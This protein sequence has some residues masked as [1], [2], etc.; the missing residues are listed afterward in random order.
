MCKHWKVCT[1]SLILILTVGRPFAFHAQT[2]VDVTAQ[3]RNAPTQ[4]SK[5]AKRPSNT[6]PAAIWLTPLAPTKSAP[7]A[8]TGN[9]TLL[10]KDKQFSPHVLV[11]PVGAVVHF[12]NADPFFHNVFSRFD[13]RRFDLGL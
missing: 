2:P 10:Q 11:V 6:P 4:P 12:P 9:Y 5:A 7:P 1:F 13:G 3:F 8:T